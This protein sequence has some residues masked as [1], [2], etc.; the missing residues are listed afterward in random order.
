MV[1][2]PMI[3]IVPPLLSFWMFT[4]CETQRKP[5]SKGMPESPEARVLEAKKLGAPTGI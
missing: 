5:M 1:G 4:G 3:G 2:A